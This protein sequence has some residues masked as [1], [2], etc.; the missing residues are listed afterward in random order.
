MSDLSVRLFGLTAVA[1]EGESVTPS[2]GTMGLPKLPGV[3]PKYVTVGFRLACI[4]FVCWRALV[5]Q[6]AFEAEDLALGQHEVDPDQQA[7]R[8]RHPNLV[9]VHTK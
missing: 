9:S 6:A 8:Q 2:F 3:F 4:E 5:S 1:Q 7:S